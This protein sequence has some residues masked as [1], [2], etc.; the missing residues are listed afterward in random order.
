MLQKILFHFN[1]FFIFVGNPDNIKIAVEGVMPEDNS[2][3]L[4]S[5]TLINKFN[6]M[7]KAHDFEEA[8]G[9]FQHIRQ[10]TDLFQQTALM[11]IIYLY[12]VGLDQKIA[13]FLYN[14]FEE[15]NLYSPTTDKKCSSWV[16]TNKALAKIYKE[17]NVRKV[18]KPAS[19]LS[20]TDKETNIPLISHYVWVTS[21][22]LSAAE[23]ITKFLQNNRHLEEKLTLLAQYKHIMWV[24]DL[25][26]I[27]PSVKESLAESKVELKSLE[28]LYVK[29]T[30]NTRNLDIDFLV[31]TAHVASEIGLSAIASDIMRYLVTK[32]Y[33]GIYSDGDYYFYKDP[34]L[35]LANYNAVIGYEAPFI[36][37]AFNGFYAATPNHQIID[38]ILELTE[39]NLKGEKAPDYAK[40]GCYQASKTSF[41]AGIPLFSTAVQL[42]LNESTDLLLKA[43]MVI[44]SNEPKDNK[45]YNGFGII[46]NDGFSGS[47]KDF[48]DLYYD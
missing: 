21:H 16:F 10:K 41:N 31:A 47:W 17:E 13:K 34:A 44:N 18:L 46:G 33:G 29:A 38:K 8:L 5:P 23:R 7:L 2:I 32:Q 9:Y 39:R 14:N 19:T 45:A 4:T 20:L 3:T 40:Y 11:K 6:A 12:Y 25:N 1:L 27:P 30:D 36:S 22:T 28:E 26:L 43:P 35:L 24:N 48:T 15:F 37:S 42:T